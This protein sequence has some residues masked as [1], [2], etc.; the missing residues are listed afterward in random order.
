MPRS[1]KI[2]SFFHIFALENQL[3]DLKLNKNVIVNAGT[4][5]QKTCNFDKK[6]KRGVTGEYRNLFW[7]F[8]SN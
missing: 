4:G 7:E 2:L 5:K 3:G 1:Y 6:K 8:F